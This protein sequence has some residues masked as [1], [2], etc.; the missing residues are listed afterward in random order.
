MPLLRHLEVSI[1]FSVLFQ[2]LHSW[3]MTYITSP[4][5]EFDVSQGEIWLIACIINKVW[6]HFSPSNMGWCHCIVDVLFI[7]E[8]FAK[9]LQVQETTRQNLWSSKLSSW[10]VPAKHTSKMMRGLSLSPP[11]WKQYLVENFKNTLGFFYYLKKNQVNKSFAVLLILDQMRFTHNIF[12]LTD[13][14]F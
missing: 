8:A 10:A 1:V 3:I 7:S 12:L 4:S 6:Q 14:E 11:Q 5:L 2:V 9:K 13:S